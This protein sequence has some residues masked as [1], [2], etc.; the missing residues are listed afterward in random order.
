MFRYLASF[1]GII[2]LTAA[3]LKL[4]GM[5]VDPVAKV[6][7]LSVP[8]FQALIVIFELLLGCWLLSGRNSA[9][10]WLVT[11]VTFSVFAVISGYAAWIGQSSCGCLGR[12]SVSPWYALVFDIAILALLVLS[13]PN[14]HAA[15]ESR[16]VAM[17]VCGGHF[18]PCIWHCGNTLVSGSLGAVL[19]WIFICRAR[20]SAWRI[21]FQR[22]LYRG[23]R[24]WQSWDFSY[25]NCP[26]YQSFYWSTQDCRGNCRLSLHHYWY[27]ANL[28]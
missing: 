28:P 14:L 22:T 2:L 24:T 15:W 11:A 21:S 3:G 7:L 19:L 13:K 23:Y 26:F 1:I 6:G 18:T 9:E 16:K 10:A 12:I 17:C 5:A 8:W 4:Y 20:L 27:V 25:R